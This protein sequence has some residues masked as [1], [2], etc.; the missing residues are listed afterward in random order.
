MVQDKVSI[1]FL[2]SSLAPELEATYRLMENIYGINS[3]PGECWRNLLPWANDAELAGVK[4]YYGKK[5]CIKTFISRPP[6]ESIQSS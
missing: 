6:K 2:V 3:I 5:E 4:C 1:L